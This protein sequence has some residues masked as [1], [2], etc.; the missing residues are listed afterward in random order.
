M[1]VDRRLWTFT[2]GVRSR[3]AL[4]VGVG[5]AAAAAG[6]A[7]LAALGWLLAAALQGADP[8]GLLLPAA[9]TVFAMLARAGLEYAR[10]MLAHRTAAQ[11]QL[12]LRRRL[13]DRVTAL[14]P[15]HFGGAR[16][17]DVILAMVEG[18]EQLE[19]YFGQYLPQLVVAAAVPPL[20]FL[21]MAWLDL[22][23]AAVLLAAAV[24]TLLAPSLFHAWDRERS[25]GR[26]RA[27][28]AYGAE[29]LDAVQG[30][31][32]LKAFGRAGER[33]A[34][35][36]R[37]AHELTRSTLMVLASNT[38]ARGITD[39]GIAVGAA[40]AVG[41]GAWRVEA[42]EMSLAVLLVILMLGV[43][44]FRPLR[45]L[46]SLLHQ[47]MLG[48]SAAESIFALLVQRP[49]VSEPASAV[50][51]AAAPVLP[52]VAFERVCFAYPGG[53]QPAHRGLEFAVAAGERVGIVGASGA[54]KSTVLKLLLRFH[55]VDAGRILVG[56]EDVRAMPLERLRRA[57]AVVGQDAYLFHGTVEDNLRLGRPDAT[58]AD[59]EAACRAAN[60]H[61]F[62]ERL[63][64]GYRTV[65]GERGVRL[66]GGQRQRIAIARAL[67][68]D[69]PILVLDEALSAVDAENEAL[70]RQA[71]DGL[72]RGRTTLIFAHRLSSVIDCDRI[73]VLEEGAVAEAG[74]HAEL[75]AK[76]GLYHRLM[77]AQAQA[78]EGDFDR[79]VPSA[80]AA[81]ADTA[82]ALAGPALPVE[83]A[84]DAIVKADGLGWPATLAVL[85]RLVRPW[86]GKL[87]LTFG[88]GVGRVLCFIGI[89]VLSALLVRAV[90][91][92]EPFEPWLL[93]VLLAAPLA[94]LLHWLEAW[95]AHDVA[96]RLLADLRIRL[97]DKLEKLAPAFQARRRTGD[98]VAL[99]THDVE[100]VEYFVAHTITPA[101]VALLVPSAALATLAT[102]HPALALALAPFLLAVGLSPFLARRRIDALGSR[103]REA[104]GDLNA[105]AVD[106]VQGLA[107]IAAFQAEAARRDG[108]LAA[109]RRHHQLRL[110]FFRELTLQTV[111]QELATGLGGLAVAVAGGLLATNGL[112]DAGL[113]P[114]AAILAMAAFLPVSEI[115][116][117]GRQLADTL[118]A[119]RRLEAVEREP[120]AVADGPAAPP[121]SRPGVPALRLDDVRFRYPTGHRPALD[122]ISFEV[123]AGACVALVGPSGAGKSTV[124]QL[125]MRFWDP[126][127][128][129]VALNG[130]DLR[131]LRLDGLR[132]QVALVAQDT[133]LFNQ[134]LRANI[135]IGRPDADDR[136]VAEAVARAGL[137]EFVASLPEG[138]ATSVGERGVRLSGGQR[139]RVAIARAFLKDA[140]ILILDEAT[141]HLDAV[142]EA[143]VRRALD[144]LM[145]NRTT[146][147]IAHRLSTVRNADRIVVLEEGRVAE[148]GNHAGLL[149]RGGL[150]AR[151]VAR[152]IEAASAASAAD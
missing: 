9:L 141:S 129:V 131:T 49:Q 28:A 1:Y 98:I 7:R 143:L 29:F 24:A 25:L 116:N 136:A 77:A 74:R 91:D 67:L 73:L 18:V 58:Q 97:F 92:G 100:M 63:P 122:G 14:G 53:R 115:A 119:T 42:G 124:A 88:L 84:E 96:Y 78:E 128:G 2:E 123:P 118:G 66:S 80:A 61:G 126:D 31:A 12:L 125:A 47:G 19:T 3:M 109:T 22:P 54:G 34:L 103:A 85:L 90:R 40:A 117:V 134:D 36:A 21:A 32:T 43:E 133:Y 137:A 10:A 139:Q 56:G 75:M 93:A 152:Q 149:A 13:F 51:A 87:S 112:L 82:P 145:R 6:V 150:Y 33:K 38:A 105:Q 70:I 138:L 71:L 55:D 17:G 151:L 111:G 20:L 114:L 107:E 65:I 35:L 8:S 106:T 99:A 110:P 15:A 30:L 60:A 59:L 52:T 79:L 95:L 57:V 23:V 89:G 130:A 81:G 44:A 120:V 148:A 94:G 144:E 86:L 48:L 16:T 69:A 135:V 4:S 132:G 62:V 121:V 64:H 104:L 5:I 147:V 102:F 26:A 101:F 11:V 41:L 83:R 39:T 46:R 113:L 45:D 108:F 146:L 140:P 142:N 37:K 76:G 68:R 72:M 50:A 127:G 27:Y